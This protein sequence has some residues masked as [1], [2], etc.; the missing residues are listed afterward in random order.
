MNFQ[1]SFLTAA[2]SFTEG[3]R[4]WE[5]YLMYNETLR[6]LHIVLVEGESSVYL[7]DRDFQEQSRSLREG[8][9]R[10]SGDEIVAVDS[11]AGAPSGERAQEFY[12]VFLAWWESAGR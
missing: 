11:R 10:R 7:I 8:T 9:V 5:L 4:A 6:E 2:E 12:D 1:P 3:G